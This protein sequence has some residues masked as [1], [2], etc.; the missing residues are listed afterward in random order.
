M[1]NPVQ[2]NDNLVQNPVQQGKAIAAGTRSEGI[3]SK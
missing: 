3:V 1:Q 2:S